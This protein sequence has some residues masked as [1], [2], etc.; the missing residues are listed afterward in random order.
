MWLVK[1][2]KVFVRRL[3]GRC[4]AAK[5]VAKDVPSRSVGEAFP[6][7]VAEEVH[8]DRGSTGA[9]KTSPQVS[10]AK[11]GMKQMKR[12]WRARWKRVLTVP[13]F[14]SPSR[15]RSWALSWRL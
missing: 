8:Q 14:R 3:Q 11:D 7:R 6:G 15:Y 5:K 4:G 10:M 12:G 9:I 1:V 2:P 13:A